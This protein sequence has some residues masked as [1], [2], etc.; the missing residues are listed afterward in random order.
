LAGLLLFRLLYY[1]VPFAISLAILGG[2]ELWLSVSAARPAGRSDGEA[3][4]SRDQTS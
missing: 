4:K 3:G 2:R 1:L